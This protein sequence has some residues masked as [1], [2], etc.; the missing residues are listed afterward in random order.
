MNRPDDL[1]ASVG[2]RRTGGNPT[3]RTVAVIT[4]PTASGKS[5]LAVDLAERQAGI[6]INADSMQ[7]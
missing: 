6:V 5:A 2:P 3:V 4:G 1:K 7:V